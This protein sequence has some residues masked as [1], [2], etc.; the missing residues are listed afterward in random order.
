VKN[1]TTPHGIRA[2]KIVWQRANGEI[3]PWNLPVDAVTICMA[4][5]TRWGRLV[6]YGD[7]K[8]VV[9]AQHP[10]HGEIW[11]RMCDQSKPVAKLMKRLAPHTRKGV[12]SHRGTALVWFNIKLKSASVTLRAVNKMLK[13]KGV[14]ERLV[15]GEGYYYFTESEAMAWYSSSVMVARVGDLT[16]DGWWHA[17]Q[18]LVAEYKRDEADAVE[19][20]ADDAAAEDRSA[21]AIRHMW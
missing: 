12:D 15:K 14:A 16:L 17:H 7:A 4:D 5:C 19:E 18:E 13:A 1:A 6:R 20:C 11:F 3:W 9:V 21:D 2:F 10:E 8:S